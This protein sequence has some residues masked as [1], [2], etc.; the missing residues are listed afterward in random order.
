MVKSGGLF[1]GLSGG[2][3]GGLSGRLSGGLSGG[4]SSGLSKLGLSNVRW[5]FVV[6]YT[7]ARGPCEC[8][9]ELS[10][11]GAEPAAH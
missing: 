11:V 1:G 6:G 10:V 2:L 4:L 9:G 3:C 5:L 8:L 7:P